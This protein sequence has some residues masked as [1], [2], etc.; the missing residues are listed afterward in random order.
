MTPFFAIFLTLFFF[1]SA[2]SL[3]LGATEAVDHE[4]WNRLQILGRITD[5][6]DGTLQR[7]FLS[8]GSRR[9]MA[10]VEN[11]MIRAGLDTWVDEIGNVHG[12]IEGAGCVGHKVLLFGSHLDTV[13]DAGKYD[14]A[15][16][17]LIGLAAV[18]ALV[19]ESITGMEPVPCSLQ[20]VAFSDEEGVRFSSTF[21]GSRALV[22]TLPDNVFKAQDNEGHTFLEALRQNGFKGTLESI[23]TA[24][25]S[26]ALASYV[27]VHIEQ[28][29]VLQQRKQHAS[30]VVGISGQT[31]LLFTVHGTQGHAGTVPMTERKDALA[32]SADI[33]H[34][35]ETYCRDRVLTTSRDNLLVCTVGAVSVWPGSSNVIPS[36]TNFTVDIRSKSD[37][38][39]NVVVEHVIEYAQ[40]VC[41][42]RGLTFSFDRTHDA[43]AVDCDDQIIN[44]FAESILHVTKD[45]T[46]TQDSADVAIS[47]LWSDSG[48]F[49]MENTKSQHAL[50]SGAGHDALA[51]SQ[52]CPIGMLFVRC[53]DG[54]SHSPQ[55]H[56]TPE[57]VAFA[58]RVLLDFLQS[59]GALFSAL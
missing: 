9:A 29:P 25:I 54:I 13:K 35:I 34:A 38:D 8:L 12:R 37:S 21:L 58:G 17:I 43:P 48:S 46:G 23:Q 6:Q 40:H 16:G 51:I 50:T 19:L 55:E 57:D 53:K 4:A 26:D 15:L 27:E 30:P 36:S 2:E 41:R 7:T 22:G 10:T 59:N 52:A 39:R 45:L 14:G 49:N 33:I 28:G 56:S 42:T 11:W 44:N 31:R 47:E 32:A 5:A 1:R 3:G 20:L 18:K 24:N